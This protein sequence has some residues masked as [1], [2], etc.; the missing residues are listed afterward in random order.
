MIFSC[1]LSDH[2]RLVFNV[3][4]L[5][6]SRIELSIEFCSSVLYGTAQFWTLLLSLRRVLSTLCA[7]NSH[8]C[9]PA[10]WLSF[11]FLFIYLLFYLFIFYFTI[12]YW[13]CHISTGICHRW[14]R[15]LVV[16]SCL[17]ITAT[18]KTVTNGNDYIVLDVCTF[19][20]IFPVL[21][22]SRFFSLLILC[23]KYLLN[24]SI[25]LPV[26]A[27]GLIQVLLVSFLY[28][29][30]SFALHKIFGVLVG[31]W[32]TAMENHEKKKTAEIHN[33]AILCV[34]VLFLDLHYHT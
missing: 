26:I 31:W 18:V 17:L 11:L 34:S 14:P 9:F 10:S 20:P 7:W 23:L 21:V 4:N 15:G 27:T 16:F 32:N 3:D 29:Q 28:Y 6:V 8:C 19:P 1:Q 13:F 22:Y 24:M 33:Y 25:P 12:L 30:K 5:H 2:C